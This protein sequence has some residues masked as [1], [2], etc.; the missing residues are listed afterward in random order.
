MASDINKAMVTLEKP[1]D[2][3]NLNEFLAGKTLEVL[4]TRRGESVLKTTK[5]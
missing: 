2:I 4:V 5:F 1:A 3:K